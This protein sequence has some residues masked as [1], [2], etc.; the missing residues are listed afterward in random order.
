MLHQINNS[1]EIN[2]LNINNW[3]K[4]KLMLRNNKNSTEIESTVTKL[5]HATTEIE[6][7]DDDK[8]SLLH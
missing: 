6:Q 8:V 1:Q 3:N 5:S 4:R 2:R 7:M